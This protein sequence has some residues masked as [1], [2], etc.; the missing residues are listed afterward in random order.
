MPS[1]KY[2]SL[3]LIK[4]LWHYT[5]AYKVKLFIGIF[6]RLASNLIWLYPAYALASIVSFLT[7]FSEGDSLQPIWNILSFWVVSIIIHIAGGMIS[8]YY[9]YQV[10]DKSALDV[11]FKTLSH[12]LKTD[13]AWHE[14]ENTGN[15]L[16]RIQSGSQGFNLIICTLF[17]DII[18]I[19]VNFVGVIFIMA[20]FDTV[21][22]S[23]IF[24]LWLHSLWFLIF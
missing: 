20:T 11:Y 18:E 8:T 15:K 7:N 19:A 14:K 24:F 13:L 16:K 17:R 10:A 9:G 4:D 21:I 2:T 12:F 23:F 22:A 6:F 5:K 1:N 3:H